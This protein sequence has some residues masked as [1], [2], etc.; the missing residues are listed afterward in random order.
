MEKLI[1]RWES[2]WYKAHMKGA[3]MTYAPRFREIRIWDMTIKEENL[4]EVLCDIRG[5]YQQEWIEGAHGLPLSRSR[6]LV[7]KLLRPFGLQEIEMPPTPS[8]YRQ[9]LQDKDGHYWVQLVP[10]GVLPDPR[11][12]DGDEME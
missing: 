1:K 3:E 8:T 9:D 12:Q 11:N 5:F 6:E 7:A 4:E 2:R 10:L